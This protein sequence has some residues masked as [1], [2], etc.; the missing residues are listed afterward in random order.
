MQKSI[1]DA[2]ANAQVEER[3]SIFQIMVILVLVSNI[4][5]PSFILHDAENHTGDQS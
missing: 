5:Y 4:I 3:V 2:N 1:G